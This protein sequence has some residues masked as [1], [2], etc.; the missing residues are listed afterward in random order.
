MLLAFVWRELGFGRMSTED[1]MMK[2]NN[3]RQRGKTYSG[4]DIEDRPKASSHRITV[5]E[6]II[7][8]GKQQ[9]FLE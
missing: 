3:E 9:G 4:Q 5:C 7:Q 8:W 1:E 6:E 2:M